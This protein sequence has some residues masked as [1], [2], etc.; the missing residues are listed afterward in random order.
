MSCS[1]HTANDIYA[2]VAVAEL[3]MKVDILQARKAAI[4]ARS[5]SPPDGGG[6]G[7]SGIAAQSRIAS[8]VAEQEEPEAEVPPDPAGEV[9]PDALA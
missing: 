8:A 6:A 5:D 9:E 2:D 4:L 7:G 1:L 3:Q